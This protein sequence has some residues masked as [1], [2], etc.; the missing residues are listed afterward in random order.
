MIDVHGTFG[1]GDCIGLLDATGHEVARGLVAY[2]SEACG[3]I[4]GQSSTRIEELL[5]YHM[6]DAVIH[7]D[8]LVVLDD[9]RARER[10]GV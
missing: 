8:D 7:R 9:E 3:R 4:M 5:G 10:G 1:V 2:D 6:G